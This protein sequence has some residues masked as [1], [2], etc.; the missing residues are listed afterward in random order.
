MILA[1]PSEQSPNRI[2]NVLGLFNRHSYFWDKFVNLVVFTS[3]ITLQ[4]VPESYQHNKLIK[5]LTILNFLVEVVCV[6]SAN[7]ILRCILFCENISKINVI[8]FISL[9]YIEI[10]QNKK[11]ANIMLC[12]KWL[13][14]KLLLIQ[15]LR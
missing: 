13:C 3:E 14:S 9:I 12:Y 7:G 6:I 10:K 5:H 8:V 2:N 11:L 15:R 1:F 4:Q